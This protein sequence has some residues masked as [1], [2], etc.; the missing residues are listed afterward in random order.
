MK[1]RVLFLCTGNSCRSQMAEGF[2]RSLA[3][4]RF[5]VASAG[6]EPVPVNPGAIE[7]M[8]EVGIDISDH[9]SKAVKAFLGQHFAYVITVCDRASERC[10]IF[11]G[12]VKRLEWNFP[13]PAAV[14]GSDAERRRVFRQVRDEI[15]DRIRDFVETEVSSVGGSG[16]DAYRRT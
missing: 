10:P 3:G 14:T 12:A 8:S 5:E 4:D 13:D 15:A 2:L 1:P 7:A 11:P 6:T 9:E 16:K